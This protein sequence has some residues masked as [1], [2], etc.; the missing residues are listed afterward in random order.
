M[1]GDIRNFAVL[2]IET[3]PCFDA[4]AMTVRGSETPK[5]PALRRIC[6][7][8]VVSGSERDGRFRDVRAD[9]FH[10]GGIDEPGILAGMD[11]VLPDPSDEASVLVSYNG[12][13]H[14]MRV[15]RLRM[16]AGWNFSLERLGGWCGEAAGRH[17]DLMRD[18]FGGPGDRWS[19]PDLCAGL[20]FPVREGLLARPV[21]TMAADGRWDVVSEHNL[22]DAVGTFLA[23]AAWRSIELRSDLPASTAWSQVG[24]MLDGTAT[25]N[26][27]RERL[28]RHRLRQ[29][30]VDRLARPLS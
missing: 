14:D 12:T 23:Y 1:N 9:V 21:S 22:M 13:A 27:G 25:V 11:I 8:A 19:L 6:S 16:A 26:P 3:M 5:R 20:G 2:D 24:T 30:A 15:L 18:G 17:F 7:A 10:L 4:M 28:S 29:W